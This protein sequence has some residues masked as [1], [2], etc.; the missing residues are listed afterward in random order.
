LIS[1]CA[2]R[3]CPLSST[4]V[5][6]VVEGMDDGRGVDRNESMEGELAVLPLQINSDLSMD[7][8]EFQTGLGQAW[9]R[10]RRNDEAAK[11][12][13]GRIDIDSGHGIEHP[14]AAGAEGV[15]VERSHA[16]I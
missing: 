8:I 5:A 7:A 2:E 13:M 4:E 16:G 6:V 1:G 14:F 15:M 11:A 9:P 3:G 12:G 10:T